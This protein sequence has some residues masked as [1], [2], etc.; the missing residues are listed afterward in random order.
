M[1]LQGD[2]ASH[3]RPDRP[4]NATTPEVRRVAAPPDALGGSRAPPPPPPA[5]DAL[6]GQ[7]ARAVAA[8]A[9]AAA[10]SETAG[11][12]GDVRSEQFAVLMLQPPPGQATIPGEDPL[13]RR[14]LAGGM[15]GLYDLRLSVAWGYEPDVER[16]IEWWRRATPGERAARFE[17]GAAQERARLSRAG[18]G[19][20]AGFEAALKAAKERIGR[21]ERHEIAEPADYRAGP[22]AYV[23]HLVAKPGPDGPQSPAEDR[24]LRELRSANMRALWDM[25]FAVVWAAE[26]QTVDAGGV[27]T[28]RPA[29]TAERLM[30]LALAGAYVRGREGIADGQAAWFEEVLRSARRRILDQGVAELLDAEPDPAAFEAPEIV[31]EHLLELVGQAIVALERTENLTAGRYGASGVTRFTPELTAVLAKWVKAAPENGFLQKALKLPIPNAIYFL[32]GV[33][34]LVD[35]ILK[36]TDDKKR[37]VLLKQFSEKEDVKATDIVG[38]TNYVLQMCE[39]VV[40]LGGIGVAFYYW[41]Y[42]QSATKAGEWIK[43]VTARKPEYEA[44][45]PA[46]RVTLEKNFLVK[47]TPMLSLR[48]IGWLTAGIQVVTNAA[49]YLDPASTDSERAGAKL[50]F[51]LGGAGVAG[52]L[53]TG[54]GVKAVAGISGWVTAYLLVLAIGVEKTRERERANEVHMASDE[55]ASAFVVVQARAAEV[56]R[57]ANALQ[58]TLAFQD[59]ASG[60]DV[61]IAAPRGEVAAAAKRRAVTQAGAL[62]NRLEQML[63]SPK[64]AA[65]V[66]QLQA[67]EEVRHSVNGAS[68]PEEVL[69]ATAEFL[70]VVRDLFRHPE[71]T[72][73][74][75]LRQWDHEWRDDRSALADIFGLEEGLH[76]NLKDVAEGKVKS[77]AGPAPPGLDKR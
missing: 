48:S 9:E 25:R 53:T 60:R 15:P 74:R 67:F 29:T 57:D 47:G 34:S 52:M 3:A 8:R 27:A 4:S 35:G 65:P 22:I 43:W 54:L 20:T 46:T 62:K 12:A 49:V 70:G 31:R 45:I 76:D 36:A 7:L 13:L 42:E 55:I 75:R 58:E 19:A 11:S 69:A 44:T 14:A 6:A 40:A 59:K 71:R 50:G 23:R 30:R 61:W 18:K 72:V 68:S 24:L 73:A 1:P 37:A 28:Y 2:V 39:G 21:D 51:A 33:L 56:V 63:K 10:A 38:I 77:V 64:G 32:K 66:H 26:P 16:G 17:P 41:T 5:G